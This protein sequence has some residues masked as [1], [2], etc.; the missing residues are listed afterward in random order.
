MKMSAILFK[1]LGDIKY[2]EINSGRWGSG[3]WSGKGFMEVAHSQLFHKTSSHKKLFKC[4]TLR[5]SKV[6]SEWWKNACWG[7]VKFP[8]GLLSA[9]T[10]FQNCR[11]WHSLKYDWC[12]RLLNQV[13]HI[14]IYEFIIM[15]VLTNLDILS[16]SAARSGNPKKEVCHLPKGHEWICTERENTWV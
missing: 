11:E 8:R 12:A 3:E 15:L 2:L 1:W 4:L 6:S 16:H 5:M 7:S 13:I 10:S 9:V 14:K